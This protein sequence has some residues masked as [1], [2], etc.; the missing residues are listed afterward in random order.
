MKKLLTITIAIILTAC[1]VTVHAETR[2]ATVAL[3]TS[4]VLAGSQTTVSVYA[5]F[6]GEIHGLVLEVD[7]DPTALRC[8]GM[9]RGEYGIPADAMVVTDYSEPG[10]CRVGIIC[11]TEGMSGTGVLMELR[12]AAAF[13]RIGTH[14]L[15][16][17]V[18]ECFTAP[19][20]GERVDIQPLTA[21]AELIVIDPDVHAA[22]RL[23][24]AVLG[25][26]PVPD[27]GDA[28]SNG[29]VNTEDVLWILRRSIA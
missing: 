19:I 6:P 9:I 27:W 23:A 15:R 26:L 24:R 25:L 28:D 12:F 10:R 8:I 13:N 21:N 14:L 3:V 22:L 4:D 2:P 16:L 18:S 5:E 1:A 20:G 7:Y 29:A 17:T 11:P